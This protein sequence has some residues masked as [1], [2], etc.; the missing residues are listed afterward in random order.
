[1]ENKTE[2]YLDHAATTWC[3]G[4]VQNV[5]KK[6]MDTDFGNP[7]SMHSKGFE[8]E[9]HIRR[10]AETIAKT[11]KVSDKEILFTSG[12]TESNNLA[13]IG[14]ATANRRL[15]SRLV[16]TQVEHASVLRTMEYLQ[17][18]G[19]EV[20]YL[21]V[22]RD[23]IVDLDA[24]REA[25]DAKT[26]LVSVMHV[27]NEV[28]AIQPVA[29][30]ADIVHE[31]NPQALF[32]VDAVQSYGKMLLRPKK[33][34]IDLLSASG[35]K[36]HAP[37]GVGFLYKKEKVKINP[38]IFGGGQQAG[39]RSG[40]YNVPGIA[41]IAEAAAQAY[42]CLDEKVRHMYSLK[43]RLI[44]K[45][46]CIE[47]V[48]ANGKCGAE[49]APHIVSLSFPGVRSEVLLHALEEYQIYVSA[50]SACS[51]HQSAAHQG[52]S[53]TLKAMQLERE[54]AESALRFSFCSDTTAEEVDAAADRLQE[55]VPR[56]RRY[57][58]R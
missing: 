23:G 30:A 40:T 14:A 51:S 41:G 4:R 16:T 26:I 8:A 7:S 52:A 45:T 5:V 50:G 11:L 17:E 48:A 53:H 2:V 38:I 9:R 25:V 10:A 1:M 32:H 24:L 42:E 29:H 54:R 43:E 12:G 28:G 47:G 21:P 58:R 18:Q 49:S 19:F 57:T 31:K 36:I 33:L 55:L 56:L 20:V 34:G 6:M 15:G 13:L 35:H 37:K 27:N 44:E 3:S 22:D 46:S 39:L